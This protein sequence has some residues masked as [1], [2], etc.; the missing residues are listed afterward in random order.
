MG[1]HLNPTCPHWITEV[2]KILSL[3]AGVQ[4]PVGVLGREVRGERSSLRS[5]LPYQS[6]TMAVRLPV[7]ETAVGST[8]T[9]GARHVTLT[10]K[11]HGCNP[12]IAGFDSPDVLFR[13]EVSR[14]SNR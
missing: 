1:N 8:P 14:L 2:R 13:R 12:C 5:D 6:S 10:V 3:E 4:L 9:S 11:R 7:K